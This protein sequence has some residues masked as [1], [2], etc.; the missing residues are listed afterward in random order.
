[1][2]IC[3][4]NLHQK[5]DIFVGP[6]VVGDSAEFEG[7]ERSIACDQRNRAGGLVAHLHTMAKVRRGVAVQIG[8]AYDHG[9]A[10]RQ[11]LCR[12]HPVRRKCARSPCTKSGVPVK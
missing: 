11:H 4:R 5:I 8:G 6:S 9:L 3:L 7:T 10:G 12:G 2:A 1:M